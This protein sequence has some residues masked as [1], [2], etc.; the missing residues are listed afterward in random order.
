MKTTVLMPVYNGESTLEKTLESLLGQTK[1][2]DDLIVIDDASGDSSASII[3][4]Y[5]DEKRE[6]TLIQNQKQIGLAATYNKGIRSAKG[7]LIIT[8]HQ[9]ILLEKESL[10][11]LV[12]PFRDENI[13]AASHIVTHPLD[14]WKKYNFWQKCFFSRL[15]G[16]D[17]RGIDGKFD[18]FR[19]NALEKIGFFDEKNFRTAGED[20]D[21]IFK[22]KKIGKISDTDAKII[23]LHKVDPN[24]SWKDIIRKQAQ[25]SEA[26]GVLFR[27][28]RIRGITQLGKSFF[29][30]ILLLS[31]LIPYVR[32]LSTITLVAYSF[33]YTKLVYK[34]EYKD[35]RIL[36]L[37]FFNIFL[38]L[39]SL[40]YSF[41]GIIYG[42]QRI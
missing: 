26:Q 36:I 9:D 27:R 18:A 13:V 11:K 7:D 8:L 17:F 38:L 1:N 22:L 34:T 15:A 25:Y 29:R 6:Y 32:I 3:K 42:K 23:H 19:K 30:E 21:A 14:I 20:G 2:F 16:K 28:G 24:F 31:L 4:K 12:F 39:I 10:K 41:K 33:L 5:L 35:K 37:P 40:I